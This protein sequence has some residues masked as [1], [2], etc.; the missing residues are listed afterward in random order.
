[1]EDRM[2]MR[3]PDLVNE[4]FEKLAALFP[5]C[6]T[7]S[8]EG[9]AIDFDLLKQELNHAVVEGTKERYRLEWPG[10]R[11]A[12]VTANLPT[13]K[14]LRP[15]REDSVNFDTTENLYIEGDNLEVLKLLQESYLNK[16]KMIYI[17]PPYNT[18]KDFVYQDNFTGDKVKELFESGQKDEYNQ[19][20]IAN[21]ET[22]G[23][24]HSDWLSMMYTRLKL[25]RNLLTNDGVIFISIDDHE[26]HNLRKICDE[27]LGEDNWLG[28]I[29]W[30]NATDNNPTQIAIE[31]EYILVFAKNKNLLAP[32][33]KSKISDV[34]NLL[35]KIGKELNSTYEN[36][37]DLQQA[38][39]KWFREHKH[40]LWPLD[41]YKYIDKDG[42][43]TG[44]QSVHNP[45]REGYRYDIIHPVTQKPCQQPLMGYR[46]PPSTIEDLLAKG[47]ILFGDD[48]SKIIEL[49]L[50]AS[51]YSEKLSS[52]VEF[53]G[54]IGSYDLKN[55]FTGSKR[56][57]TNPKPV[58]FLSQ[59]FDF[60]LKDKD[61]LLDFFAGSSS[62]AHALLQLNTEDKGKRKFILVQV[63]EETDEKSEAY[64]SGYKN[65]CEIGKE[66][67]RR[68]AKQIV[69]EK[70]SLLTAKKNELDKALNGQLSLMEDPKIEELKEEIADLQ[71]SIDNLDTGF[72][73]YR[74]ADSNMQDVY[75]KPQEYSQR[76]LDMFA[77]N[78]KP[79]R[80]A[81]DL[82]AQVMLDWGL[83]LSLKIEQTTVFG[84][85]VFK[86]AENSLYACFDRGIDEA[87]AKEIAKDRP[88]RIVFRD[89]GF[90][91]DTAKVNVKQLLK[92]LS[93]DTEMKVL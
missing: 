57:F 13:T 56:I 62:S 51:E 46:F 93:P 47:K 60:I 41:R 48:E 50:Y 85:R 16:I 52:I 4:N 9:K 65:I 44:S 1:M 18:G 67:I 54:R 35:I 45:G 81:D 86:V 76:T 2:D 53:D 20:L 6:V 31:H 61:L 24:Y 39:T 27:I 84:K 10:K 63:P 42:I 49:K 33:W 89:S 32:V 77:D 17:D 5:H 88:L 7:E 69:N 58:K 79:D 90:K 21:P 11:E 91:D 40:E 78:V 36:H 55:V 28:T 22:A 71:S 12:I 38:Y 8:A 30:N 74:L 15:V 68:A 64:K 25:A 29:I 34:K 82:L 80:T 92:Q 72:R 73:V 43:Y 14:T 87:F 3:S 83:P 59:F 26:I 37:D 75:Y 19:R 66:R 23:R 70:V